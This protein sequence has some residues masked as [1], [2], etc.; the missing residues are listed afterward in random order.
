MER[1]KDENHDHVRRCNYNYMSVYFLEKILPYAHTSNKN[2]NAYG[3][4]KI[5]VDRRR[6][7][8]LETVLGQFDPGILNE[9]ELSNV[10]KELDAV[11]RMVNIKFLHSQTKAL[12]KFVDAALSKERTLFRRILHSVLCRLQISEQELGHKLHDRYGIH[13]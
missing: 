9:E 2:L 1:I 4:W 8:I 10:R 12:G 6:I 13:D 3:M 11:M 5:V 7:A